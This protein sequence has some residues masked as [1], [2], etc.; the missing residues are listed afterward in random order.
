MLFAG[1]IMISFNQCKK[2]EVAKRYTITGTLLES[3]GNPMPVSAYPLTLYR[4]ERSTFLLGWAPGISIDFK[5]NLNGVFSIPY[6]PEKGTGIFAINSNQPPL[7]I[8][9]SDP[10][11]YPGIFVKFFPIPANKDTSL[12]IVYVR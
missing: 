12:N 5:T 9:G 1:A 8:T 4:K 2:Q 6:T 3:A 11:M 10:V 7:E